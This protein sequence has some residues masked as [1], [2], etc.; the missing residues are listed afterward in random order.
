MEFRLFCVPDREPIDT[1]EAYVLARAYRAVW[2]S[3]FDAEPIGEHVIEGLGLAIHYGPNGD[4]TL[5]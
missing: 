5:N 3:L 1:V 4:R 2:R